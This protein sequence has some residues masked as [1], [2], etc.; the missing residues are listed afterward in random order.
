M[1]P[2]EVFVIIIIGI[3]PAL[4]VGHLAGRWQRSRGGWTVAAVL[5]GWP[6]VLV[7]LLIVGVGRPSVPLRPQGRGWHDSEDKRAA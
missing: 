4:L 3:I 6:F 1:G 5:L 7:A 2:L